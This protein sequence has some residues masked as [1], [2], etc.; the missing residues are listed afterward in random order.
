MVVLE[1]LETE[2]ITGANKH[3]VQAFSL[4]R[5]TTSVLPHN[6]FQEIIMSEKYFTSP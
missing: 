4:F 1:Y 2:S 5:R 6:I 3:T